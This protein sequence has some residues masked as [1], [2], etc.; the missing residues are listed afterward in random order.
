MKRN[1]HG[2][3]A[4]FEINEG[5]ILLQTS[6]G[7]NGLANIDAHSRHRVA[8]I[9]D[10]LKRRKKRRKKKELR[11]LLPKILAQ[12]TGKKKMSQH[13]NQARDRGTRR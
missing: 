11:K 6:T 2:R 3:Q 8:D 1:L 9:R 4:N 13:S 12:G 5:S 10:Y 7:Q